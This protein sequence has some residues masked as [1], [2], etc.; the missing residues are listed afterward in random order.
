MMLVRLQ[1]DLQKTVTS[2]R[3]VCSVIASFLTNESFSYPA[4]MW[5]IKSETHSRVLLMDIKLKTL[6]SLPFHETSR[7]DDR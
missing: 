6:V 1:A 5:A 2:L 7:V 3:M 4:M